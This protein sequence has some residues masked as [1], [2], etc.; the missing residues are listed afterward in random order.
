MTFFSFEM[1]TFSCLNFVGIYEVKFLRLS[2]EISQ[3]ILFFE[4]NQSTGKFHAC[5]PS[6]FSSN[7]V[8][9]DY[10]V[11]TF[12]PK[13]LDLYVKMLTSFYIKST[14]FF[15]QLNVLLSFIWIFKYFERNNW[16]LFA[17]IDSFYFDI[18]KTTSF[19][20]FNARQ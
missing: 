10:I 3:L 5:G 9:S 7:I 17:S 2:K 18:L 8:D 13:M 20:A 6:V 4:K 16:L 19:Q 12:F 11:L 14:S 15:K 1:L